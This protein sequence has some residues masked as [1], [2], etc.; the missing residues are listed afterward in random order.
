MNKYNL[1]QQL[2]EG[3]FANVYK[4]TVRATGENVAI[5]KMK[6]AYPHW[7]ECIRLPEVQSL[8]KLKGS[9]YI[10]RLRE[11]FREQHTLYFVFDCMDGDLLSLIKK[12]GLPLPKVRS[13]LLQILQGV[14]HIHRGGYFHRDMKPENLLYK[15]DNS[16][17]RETLKI[18]DF[19]LVKELRSNT[20]TE[21]VSTRWYRAPELLL[22]DKSYSAPID[23]FA[24]GAIAFEMLSGQPLFPGSNERDQLLRVFSVLGTPTQQSWPE[25][26]ARLQHLRLAAG[27]PPTMAK[28]LTKL[29]P[30]MTPTLSDLL[31]KMLE[32][33]PRD[34][35]T[36]AMALQHPFFAAE[37]AMSAPPPPAATAASFL[38]RAPLSAVDLNNNIAAGTT[39]K[40][41]QQQQQQQS[42]LPA[43]P[44]LFSQ[45]PPLGKMPASLQPQVQPLQQQQPVELKPSSFAPPPP[46]F[47]NS[48]SKK[49]MN[50]PSLGSAAGAAAAAAA[51]AVE[52]KKPHQLLQQQ[53][54]QQQ[55]HPFNFVVPSS[56]ATATTTTAA[57]AADKP[58]LRSASMPSSA[59]TAAAAATAS[60]HGGLPS[61]LSLSTGAASGG[62]ASGISNAAWKPALM[63]SSSGL[64]L[65]PPLPMAM[66]ATN[67]PPLGSKMGTPVTSSGFSAMPS[68]NTATMMM[69]PPT[70]SNSG[71]GNSGSSFSNPPAIGSAL[72]GINN[73]S[74]GNNKMMLM[75]SV[76]SSS[77]T[78]AASASAT[79]MGNHQLPSF[80]SQSSF[81]GAAPKG[82][83]FSGSGLFGVPAPQQQQQQTMPAATMAT[84]AS[85]PSL[86]PLGSALMTS[87][88]APAPAPA[89][90]AFT[91]SAVG[92]KPI[93]LPPQQHQQQQQSV[94]NPALAP[95]QKQPQQNSAAT[96]A[97]VSHAAEIDA[98]LAKL[99]SYQYDAAASGEQ[100]L[101]PLSHLPP[102][103]MAASS[104]SS[105]LAPLSS[106]RKGLQQALNH[107]QEL[108]V[109][110]PV[111]TT[112]QAQNSKKNGHA[113]SAV[114][115][116]DSAALAMSASGAE[117]GV[118]PG[119][120]VDDSSPLAK[121]LGSARYVCNSKTFASLSPA[122]RKT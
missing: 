109:V 10:I 21:Y 99:A 111:L 44:A 23:V 31:A 22:Q 74:N 4:A 42:S 57:T 38:S 95:I 64:N 69:M 52:S 71:G 37:N 39:S 66:T 24:V 30:K 115:A 18:A 9:P 19:G 77:T 61:A 101:V 12:G 113:A 90:P 6:Q 92:C 118:Q 96:A 11:V 84:A 7:D 29:C 45:P 97:P 85:K 32:L 83:S 5:K 94:S 14:A 15:R 53:Q 68:S 51:L 105:L 112:L 49:P 2:G 48:N 75:S 46:Q 34:R 119:D 107:Q 114:A 103:T 63:S 122:H 56:T 72:S 81:G 73:S 36:A 54:Q 110:P 120:V 104:S 58:P 41:L 70:F 76:P 40:A 60:S 82:G 28:D 33:N 117:G 88:T 27:L 89:P 59:T 79:V 100:T 50:P 91:F 102:A 25:G 78:T 62:V 80:A 116:L 108:V 16:G 1:Q 20:A 98:L 8:Q 86:Q 87:S 35:V 121:L 106:K 67:P 13:F 55:K 93:S 47:V 17:E 26:V 65:P 43:L 3:T